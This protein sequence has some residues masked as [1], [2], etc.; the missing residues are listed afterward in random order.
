MY[1]LL[2]V[3]VNNNKEKF[4]T[5]STYSAF[6]EHENNKVSSTEFGEEMNTSEKTVT[7]NVKKQQHNV[8]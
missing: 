6:G 3:I 4:C 7:A 5:E 8:H 2:S 1:D